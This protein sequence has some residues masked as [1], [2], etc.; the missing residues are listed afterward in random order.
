MTGESL[1][2]SASYPMGSNGRPS[3][4]HRGSL[5]EGK[6]ACSVCNNWVSVNPNSLEVHAKTH[7]NFKQ[8]QCGYCQY[9]SCI[10]GKVKRHLDNVHRGQDVSMLSFT[11]LSVGLK[12]IIA[13]TRS[14]CF[15]QVTI[16]SLLFFI[17]SIMV[18]NNFALIRRVYKVS[19]D[20]KAIFDS[21]ISHSSLL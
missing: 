6:L 3:L 10:A 16:I 12:Q 8:H 14:L 7:L 5:A 13:D 11:A 2:A 4:Q 1:G 19:W 15:P 21:S 9:R 17:P 18:R 20:I